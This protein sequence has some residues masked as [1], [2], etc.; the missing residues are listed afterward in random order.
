M[1]ATTSKV[2]FVSPSLRRPGRLDLEIE[3]GVP[4]IRGRDQ[5]L[6]IY[7]SDSQHNLSEADIEMV[8]RVSNLLDQLSGNLVLK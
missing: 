8:A 6:R 7:L 3:V 2:E 4:D 5:I 1:I